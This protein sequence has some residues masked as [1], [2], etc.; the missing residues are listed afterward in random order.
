MHLTKTL[1]RSVIVAFASLSLLTA[2][3]E[4]QPASKVQ[5]EKLTDLAENFEKTS[6]SEAERNR[7]GDLFNKL[8][9]EEMEAFIDLR[10][11][12]SLRI[13]DMDED[14]AAY[15]RDLRHKV[16]RKAFEL[17]KQP[18]HQL[19]FADSEEVLQIVDPS[20][21]QTPVLY[22]PSGKTASDCSANPPPCTAWQGNGSLAINLSATPNQWITGSY[23]GA[24]S[25]QC[26]ATTFQTDCDYVFR[27]N[28]SK[29]YAAVAWRPTAGIAVVTGTAATR[30]ID[31]N[32]NRVDC[33]T[34]TLELLYG[35]TRIDIAFGTPQAAVAYLQLGISQSI[36]TGW[37]YTG[38]WGSERWYL[39]GDYAPGWDNWGR[40]NPSAIN[41][42]SPCACTVE[43]KVVL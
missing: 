3:Q 17:K 31:N 20:A 40:N 39:Y 22:S 5:M 38:S 13:K 21:A 35:K 30:L 27:W 29:L 43:G 8:T 1:Y 32:P 12:R 10:Y 2:C 41:S 15:L 34:Y 25:L 18:F 7:M 19:N 9:Y 16:N 23:L 42:Y 33:G 11:E 37:C 36:Q 24:R 6:L 26:T 14:R 4:E 28:Y